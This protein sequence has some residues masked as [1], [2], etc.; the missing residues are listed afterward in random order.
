VN[1]IKLLHYCIYFSRSRDGSPK[2]PPAVITPAKAKP[3]V[4]DDDDDDDEKLSPEELRSVRLR[5]QNMRQMVHKEVK[6][7]G[8][9]H[10]Q[11][12]S[13]LKGLHGPKRVCKEYICEV[14]AEARRF[15]RKRLAEMLEGAAEEL[16]KGSGGKGA[17]VK[18]V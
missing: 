1:F 7:P 15:K 9:D 12:M 13:M 18:E 17:T 14:A 8:R 11:L 4:E 3:E 2:P 10:S 16:V 6:R 5:N